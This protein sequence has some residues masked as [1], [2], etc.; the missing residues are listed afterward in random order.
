MSP[1]D[2]PIC[3]VTGEDVDE[4]DC[5]VAFPYGKQDAADERLQVEKDERD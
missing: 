4:C 1:Y 2:I 3:E 5:L